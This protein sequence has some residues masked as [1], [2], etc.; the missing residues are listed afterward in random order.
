MIKLFR[1]RPSKPV[2]VSAPLT[3]PA[4]RRPMLTRQPHRTLLQLLVDLFRHHAI[5]PDSQ[6]AA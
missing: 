2:Q 1:I 3:A 5:L 4:D 6:Q